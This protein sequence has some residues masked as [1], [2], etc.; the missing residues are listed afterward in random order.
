MSYLSSLDYGSVSTEQ[1]P[2]I[3]E[4]VTPGGLSEVKSQHKVVHF[5][6]SQLNTEWTFTNDAG[7]GSGAM[8]DVIDDGYKI[9]T[10]ASNNN[11]SRIHF[12]DIRHY[13]NTSSV[14]IMIAKIGSTST[15]GARMGL[16]N[17]QS[18]AAISNS[19]GFRYF[20][21]VGA[22]FQGSTVDGSTENA[23]TLTVADTNFHTFQ[24]E[25]K[26]TAAKFIIDGVLEGVST[27]NLPTS[28]MDPF[29]WIQT[30]TT[31]ASTGNIRFMEAYNT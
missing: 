17:V 15:I 22:N 18:V 20:S 19:I 6:G 24:G 29:L 10:G 3:Y 5:S 23:V 21:T 4:T 25:L 7:S 13:S 2:S 27:S 31:A 26:T 8:S 11:S 30:K 12:N 14:F 1:R 9:T 28:N 16:A